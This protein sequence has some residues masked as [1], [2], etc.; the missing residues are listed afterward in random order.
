MFWMDFSASTM[1]Q[2]LAIATGGIFWFVW[3][4]FGGARD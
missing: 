4:L 1:S 2:I 3:I